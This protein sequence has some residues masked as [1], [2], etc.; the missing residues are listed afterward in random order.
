MS[1]PPVVRNGSRGTLHTELCDLLGCTYPILQAG[2][3]GVARSELVAAV[4][5]AGAY[6]FLGMVRESP[7]MIRREI[8]AVREISGIPFGVNLIPAATD[9]ELFKAELGVCLDEGIHSVCFFWDVDE[10]AVRTAKDAGALVLYQVGSVEDALLAERAGADAVIAQGVEAGGHVR[11]MVSSLVLLPQVVGAVGVPVVASGGFASGEALVAALA[12]G[13]Q[14]IHCGTA[15]LACRE[16]FAHE[17]HKSIVVDAR[18]EDTVHTTLFSINWPPQSPVRV[19]RNSTYD[20]RPRGHDDCGAEDRP[21]DVIAH[22]DSRPIYRYSTDSPLRNT[23]G[24]IDE[25]ALFAGQACGSIRDIPHAAERVRE[26][27]AEAEARLARLNSRS[28]S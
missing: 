6:G 12:L 19:I 7:D 5:I 17:Y 9:T 23:T 26:F 24:R 8:R 27:V 11:G 15:F 18:S 2:M 16:S 13:C 14:G 20:E 28:S 22:E 4:S 21:R 10:E 25:L 1:S 3:G